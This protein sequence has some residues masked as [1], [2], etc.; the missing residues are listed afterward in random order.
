MES[1]FLRRP[2][3]LDPVRIKL[4]IAS[5]KWA[6]LFEASQATGT[7]RIA[8][9]EGHRQKQFNQVE[10]QEWAPGCPDPPQSH[11]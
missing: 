10:L 5:P 1:T 6:P 11:S 9:T 7:P 4:T 8:M 2:G 3:E